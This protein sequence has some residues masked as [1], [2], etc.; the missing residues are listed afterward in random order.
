MG[1]F[2]NPYRFR[3]LLCL[4]SAYC[5]YTVTNIFSWIFSHTA[6]FKACFEVISHRLSCQSLLLTIIILTDI[7]I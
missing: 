6:Y 7:V 5:Y 2:Q 3:I 1:G 4:I